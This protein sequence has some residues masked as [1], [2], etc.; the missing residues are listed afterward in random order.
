M[1]ATWWLIY[2]ELQHFFSPTF[3]IFVSGQKLVK[4]HHR[5]RHKSLLSCSSKSHSQI[6]AEVS[7][8]FVLIE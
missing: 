1:G 5:V 4:T 8:C 7:R 6:G 3:I 2:L